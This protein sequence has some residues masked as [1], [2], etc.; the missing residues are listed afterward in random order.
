MTEEEVEALINTSGNEVIRYLT[1]SS[2]KVLWEEN[3]E[4]GIEVWSITEND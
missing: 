3:D 2:K 4:D 1:S